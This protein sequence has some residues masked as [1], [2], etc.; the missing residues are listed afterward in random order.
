MIRRNQILVILVLLIVFSA[1]FAWGENFRDKG[2]VYGFKVGLISPGSI[3]VED[4]SDDGDMSYSLGGFVDYA[5]AEKIYGGIS[6][7]LHNMSFYDESKIMYDISGTL[8]AKIFSET[9][10][11]TFRPGIAIGYGG[12]PGF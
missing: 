9:S 1:S 10:N 3:D 5:L 8:K 11:L 4:F 12:I 2:T 7:D 6:L